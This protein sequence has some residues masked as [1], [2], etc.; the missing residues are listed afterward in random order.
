MI[1][2]KEYVKPIMESEEFAAN[3]Y[4]ATCVDLTYYCVNDTQQG[5]H[6]NHC[7]LPKN[8]S[9][10]EATLAVKNWTDIETY[11]VQELELEIA[12]HDSQ[13]RIIITGEGNL[14]SDHK[15]QYA[16]NYADPRSAS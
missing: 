11:L 2:K 8:S 4:V 15:I 1:M 6:K 13:N 5:S 7:L 14:K 9:D 12:S 16:W 10:Q 3:E